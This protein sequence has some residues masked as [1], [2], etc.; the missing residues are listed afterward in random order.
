MFVVND[1]L[2][3]YATRGDTVFFNV[4]AHDHGYPYKFQPGDIVRMAIYGKKEA[5]NCVMQKD[6]PV[7]EVTESVF[8][9]LEEEDTKIGESISKHKDYWYE[10]VLNPD[11][12]PQTLVGYDEDGAKIFRLFPESEELGEEVKPEPEDIPVVDAELDMTSHRPIENQAVARAVAT[13]L[14]VVERTNAA[15]AENFVTPEM[16][17]AIGDGVADDTEAVQLAILEND[18]VVL[19][20]TYL[21]SD[22][23]EINSGRSYGG[24]GGKTVHGTGALVM[25]VN[26]DCL[27]VKGCANNVS[28][29]T[30]KYHEKFYN[31]AEQTV[32]YDSALLSLVS[33]P[34]ILTNNNRIENVVLTPPYNDH[35][36]PQYQMA[37]GIKML[38]GAGAYMYNNNFVDCKC[39]GMDTA[40][41]IIHE[42]NDL[43]IN[44]NRFDVSAW[45]CDCYVDGYINGCVISGNCQ[46]RNTKANGCLFRNFTGMNNVIDSYL[47]DVRYAGN[48]ARHAVIDE[49]ECGTGV[50]YNT[51]TAP[52][53]GCS[54]LNYAGLNRYNFIT[55]DTLNVYSPWLRS[56]RMLTHRMMPYGNALEQCAKSMKLN[57]GTATVSVST[58]RYPTY[59]TSTKKLTD[60]S[61]LCS[62]T[63]ANREIYLK[64]ADGETIEITFDI[65]NSVALDSIYLEHQN[66][67]NAVCTIDGVELTT[68]HNSYV[69]SFLN[70]SFTRGSKV[71]ISFNVVSGKTGV[72]KRISAV[73]YDVNGGTF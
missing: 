44:A 68:F 69:A 2:S 13:I 19:N 58:A 70:D 11:T 20:G 36:A 6:F 52:I 61:E 34:S 18:S 72:L 28:G 9:Y 33:D 73:G 8:I 42:G 23:I 67:E 10:V 56:S 17:G 48:K 7:E 15:V 25:G 63:V 49:A 59:N 22:T 38:C 46:S 1:D 37:T 57:Q 60:C 51:F 53:A 12:I 14:D 64:N 65:T 3:I 50:L 66:L 71:V 24:T 4:T 26:K 21:V 47:F 16:Y 54:V 41:R 45:C 29:I 5:T 35:N 40:I 31:K 30:I 43:G 39:Y 62:K 55:Q 32:T 27:V